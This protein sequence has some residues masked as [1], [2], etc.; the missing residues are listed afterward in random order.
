M[1]KYK[2]PVPKGKLILGD[3]FL[4]P[5][6]WWNENRLRK[7]WWH[8]ARV[9]EVPE[10]NVR[11]GY[12]VGYMLASLDGLLSGQRRMK[13]TEDW[14]YQRRFAVEVKHEDRIFFALDRGGLEIPLIF[15]RWDWLLATIQNMKTVPIY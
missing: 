4:P 8:E 9:L 15:Y 14:R 11:E 13:I 5:T 10:K 2:G 12:R 3:R 1:I 7:E 6:R